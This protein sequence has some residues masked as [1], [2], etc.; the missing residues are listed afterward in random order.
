MI[1]FPLLL[2]LGATG[3]LAAQVKAKLTDAPVICGQFE[4]AKQ[5]KGFKRPLKSSGV[6]T[7]KKGEGVQWNTLKPFPAELTVRAGDIT[8]KQ[9]GQE[10]FKLDAKTEPSVRVIT[11][12][13]F[14][15]LAGDLGA[16][17]THFE[18]K[19]EV[20]EQRWHIELTPKTEGLKKVFAQVKLDG[21]TAVRAVQLQ[22]LSGDSTAITLTPVACEAGK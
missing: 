6:F 18:A 11:E 20:G 19:G 21:D 15:L 7:V 16:L 8:S 13:L 2:A 9:G 17:S 12:L 1:V 4:Q 14:S 3:D 22:E 5:V 10:V